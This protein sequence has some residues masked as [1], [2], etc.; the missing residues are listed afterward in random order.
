MYS[1]LA[2]Q[3]QK[4]R[5]IR[6]YIKL[7]TCA[8]SLLLCCCSLLKIYCF[9][10]EHITGSFGSHF[11]RIAEGNCVSL[12]Y[13]YRYVL[14]CTVLIWIQVSI[15]TT[16]LI[17]ILVL[18]S[19]LSFNDSILFEYISISRSTLQY[20]TVHLIISIRIVPIRSDSEFT[21]ALPVSMCS[22]LIRVAPPFPLRA[23]VVYRWPLRVPRHYA[24]ASSRRMARGPI[25][26]RAPIVPRNYRAN[27]ST[28]QHS[29]AL[30]ILHKIHTNKLCE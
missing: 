8:L 21:R 9:H 13:R 3:I 23:R 26:A 20:C 29:T 24:Y 2:I 16:L 14:Y 5:E 10:I 11:V 12:S 6:L 7:A 4:T 22:A 18:S 25:G 30:H 19:A 15:L 27:W 1:A 17:S 28:A